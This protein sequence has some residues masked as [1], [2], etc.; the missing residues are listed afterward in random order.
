[1]VPGLDQSGPRDRAPARPAGTCNAWPALK[2]MELLRKGSRLSIQPVTAAQWK[3]DHGAGQAE[4]KN[5]KIDRPLQDRVPDYGR[6][7]MSQIEHF[8]VYADDADRAERLLRAT[9]WA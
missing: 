6:I 8:A 1:M 3:T 5:R 4:A 9:P 7:T 2:G